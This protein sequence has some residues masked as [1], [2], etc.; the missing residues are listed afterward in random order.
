MTDFLGRLAEKLAGQATAIEPVI[1]PRYGPDKEIFTPDSIAGDTRGESHTADYEQAVETVFPAVP[2]ALASPTVEQFSE[3]KP[4]GLETYSTQA[5]YN[6]PT[7]REELIR[8]EIVRHK[9]S[10]GEPPASSSAEEDVVIPARTREADN[11]IPSITG[12]TRESHSQKAN[13]LREAPSASR[14]EAEPS[15]LSRARKR[16]TNVK[17]LKPETK[18][19][20]EVVSF[21]EQS[22][23]TSPADESQ[24]DKPLRKGIESASKGA[25][26]STQIESR[27]QSTEENPA[28][29][30]ENFGHRIESQS[31]I[32][33]VDVRAAKRPDADGEQHDT[34]M[35]ER[36]QQSAR[37]SLKQGEIEIPEN[38]ALSADNPGA[39]RRRRGLPSHPA[40][41]RSES[42][43]QTAPVIK[44]TIGRIE[45]RAISLPPP[46]EQEAALP[47]PRMSLDDY[48]KSFSGGRR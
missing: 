32:R 12:P 27:S 8:P 43:I 31:A 46:Q 3:I 26:I 47:A 10:P 28:Y 7:A 34:K 13:P 4:A 44:V 6:A 36:Q 42:N 19:Q 33:S 9:V 41:E 40:V 2:P 23:K 30:L 20:P 24:T 5:E 39:L 45:V 22:G 16:A 17:P 15:A 18:A 11:Q 25:R 29:N 48:L 35:T 37:Q 38:R 1:A 21:V 14:S